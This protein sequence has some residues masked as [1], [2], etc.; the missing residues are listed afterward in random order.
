MTPVCSIPDCDVVLSDRNRSGLCRSCVARRTNADPVAI[1][2]RAE[3]IR[4]RFNQPGIREEYAERRRRQNET[5]SE[6]E[7]AA[8]SR[9]GKKM[10]PRLAAVSRSMTAEQRAENGR[11]RTATTLAWCPPEWRDVYRSYARRG[12]KAAEAKQITLD[13]IAGKPRVLY[14]Q[15]KAK[16][17][18]CP[19]ERR[20][21]YDRLAKVH[22][23]NS[24]KQMLLDDMA[25]QE[26]RRLAAMTPFERM[27]ER[28]AKGAQLVD[29]FVPRKADHA[30]T[31]G[32]VS[33]MA[34]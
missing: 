5:P 6:I 14:A 19:K 10:A 23:A 32:G 13:L 9:Q 3:A 4:A 17:A 24:A 16:L 31:L 34:A 2:R 29:K 25:V 26:R 12:L 15:Q 21:E 33:E 8:R 1:A 11:K 20:S 7:R 22:G 28:V 18:W 30:F 27:Q